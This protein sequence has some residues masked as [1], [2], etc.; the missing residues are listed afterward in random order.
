MKNTGIQK[1]DSIPVNAIKPKKKPVLKI[2]QV[3]RKL[4]IAVETIRMYEREGLIILEKTETGQRL[5]Y[6]EDLHWLI[7]IRR[8]IKDE[9]LNIEGIRRLLALLPCWELRPCS[10]E[11]R[12]Q[13]PAY[14]GALKPCWMIK[15]QIPVSCR[16]E[17]C[18][19]C[20]VYQ[21]ASRC[22][23]LK[24]LLFKIKH[25]EIRSLTKPH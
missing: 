18:R 16:A 13:C 6:D 11:E 2:G 20:P 25:Q 8:L 4:D 24:A 17:N 5:F 22:E 12:R 9:G 1:T 3:A 19:E 23:N 15:S 10:L 7:C 14:T 21:N